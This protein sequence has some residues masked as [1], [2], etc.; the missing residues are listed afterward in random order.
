[1]NGKGERFFVASWGPRPLMG[2]VLPD[3]YEPVL[4]ALGDRVM[5]LRGFERLG[6]GEAGVSPKIANQG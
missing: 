5:I 3:L 4:V 1:M 6:E 2:R